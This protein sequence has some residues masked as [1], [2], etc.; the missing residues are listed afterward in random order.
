M[1]GVVAGRFHLHADILDAGQVPRFEAPEEFGNESSLIWQ[2]SAND[3][4]EEG[5]DLDTN[6]RIG[7]RAAPLFLH[8][9]KCN[10]L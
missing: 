9:L 8:I 3:R 10:S 2:E 7:P 5:N 1:K 4:S 6:R